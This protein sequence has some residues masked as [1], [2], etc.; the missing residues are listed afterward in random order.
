M[1]VAAVGGTARANLVGSV[2][3][4]EISGEVTYWA[5]GRQRAFQIVMGGARALHGQILTV[6]INGRALDAVT[7]TAFGGVEL[8]RTSCR[9]QTVPMI[10]RGST[11]RVTTAVGVLVASGMF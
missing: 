8:R 7:V 10:S 5:D 9:G 11:V 4:P 6:V 1:S 2:V 3:H